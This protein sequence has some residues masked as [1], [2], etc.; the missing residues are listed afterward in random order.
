MTAAANDLQHVK[1]NDNMDLLKDN[2]KN[3]F[4]F[5]NTKEVWE[6]IDKFYKND[7]QGNTLRKINN[8]Q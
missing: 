4:Q 3:T 5:L 1:R 6:D 7:S 2:L 8:G